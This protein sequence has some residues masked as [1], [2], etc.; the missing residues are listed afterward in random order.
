LFAHP[1]AKTSADATFGGEKRLKQLIVRM[2][3]NANSVVRDGD[4][5]APH[6]L[7]VI[8]THGSPNFDSSALSDSI[9]TID[10]QVREDLPYLPSNNVR[11]HVLSPARFDAC[12]F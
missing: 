5:K 1:K 6:A 3:W 8:E 4:P 7:P 10:Q 12:L 11:T 9:Q 2:P